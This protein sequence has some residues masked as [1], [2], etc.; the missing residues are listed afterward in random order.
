MEIKDTHP[1][2]PP[3]PQED[4]KFSC[5]ATKTNQKLKTQSNLVLLTPLRRLVEVL[6]KQKLFVPFIKGYVQTFPVF[7]ACDALGEFQAL[8]PF[9]RSN[10]IDT[11]FRNLFRVVSI[12]QS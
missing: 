11:E 5:I 3:P 2:P 10:K 6:T 8:N 7:T 12:L 4:P 1:P 9:A